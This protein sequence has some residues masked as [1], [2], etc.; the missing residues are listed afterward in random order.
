MP[1]Y[2]LSAVGHHIEKAQNIKTDSLLALE[3]CRPLTVQAH[4]GDWAR[5]VIPL[6]LR[7][8][9]RVLSGHPDREFAQFV[10]GG[11]RDGFRIGF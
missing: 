1:S 3:A 11:I 4:D 9:E 7:E 8:W 2:P 10:C 6:R 5:I